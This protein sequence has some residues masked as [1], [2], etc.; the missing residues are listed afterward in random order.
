MKTIVAI[1]ARLNSSRLPGKALAMAGTPPQPLVCHTWLAAT[2]SE[3]VQELLVATDSDEIA[4]ALPLLAN[5]T[6]DRSE[7]PNG[8]RR[9]HAAL[10]ARY[11]PSELSGAI[12]VNWQ[13]DEP[14]VGDKQLDMLIDEAA[15][16][17]GRVV[18][19]VRPLRKHE[20]YDRNTVKAVLAKSTPMKGQDARR[21]SCE[22][23]RFHRGPSEFAKWAHVGI[24]AFH[25]EHLC[26][27]VDLPP[28]PD[29]IRQSLEQLTWH[30]RDA[31]LI[32]VRARG[33]LL[34][35]NTPADLE[36]WRQWLTQSQQ[37]S[38]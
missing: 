15:L 2:A 37:L 12:V 35:I 31:R 17:P 1:P 5:V 13:V 19:L 30:E 22:I 32:G 10:Q 7:Y 9:V 33:R 25:W 16:H 24:Y 26:R 21:A 36:E 23:T 14:M 20:R 27:L 18:T 29:A 6:V 3:R 4:A 34:G 11:T 8:T 38:S 28:H